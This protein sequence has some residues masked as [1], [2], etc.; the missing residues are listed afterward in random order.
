MNRKLSAEDKPL[1]HSRRSARHFLFSKTD[2]GRLPDDDRQLADNVRQTLQSAYPD[3]LYDRTFEAH[4]LKSL[5]SVDR[6][7]AIV[8]QADPIKREKRTTADAPERDALVRIAAIL[9]ALCCAENGTWG[10]IASGDLAGYF[11]DKNAPQ[12]SELTRSMQ[13]EVLEKTHQSITVGIAAYPTISYAK[14][15][16]LANAAK[17]LDHALFFGPNSTAVFDSVSL[18]ISGDKLFETGDIAAAIQELQTALKMDPSNVNVHNSLGVCYG[19][20]GEYEQA[21]EAFKS[22][23]VL[24]PGE[25]MALYN[26]G[27]TYLLT[28]KR[29]TALDF[30]LKADKI[31][32]D[33]YEAAFQA[34]KLYLEDGDPETARVYLERAADLESKSGAVYRYLG[35]CHAANNMPRE[36]IAAYRKAIKLNPRDAAAMSSL[37]CLF[38]AQGENPEI[39]LIFCRESVGL[40]PENGLFRYRLGQLLFKQNRLAEALAEFRKAQELGH[41]AAADINETEAKLAN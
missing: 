26:L 31:S 15:D 39:T 34:G 8:V 24:E 6:F 21:I 2:S 33:A 17:A 10:L 20:Q 13:T 5:D 19:I 23:V 12:T 3:L 14:S 11:P 16:I 30:F 27:L 7:T 29:D 25:Y 40:A 28:Q 35:D 1:F 22:A 37:G 38:E 4:A 32:D 36:A 9:D 41:D 18:N